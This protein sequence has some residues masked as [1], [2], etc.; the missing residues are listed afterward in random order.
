VG[1]PGQ[2]GSIQAGGWLAAITRCSSD[3][4][5]RQAIRQ[6]NPAERRA[7]ETLRS[8][9]PDSYLAHKREAITVHDREAGALADAIKQWAAARDQYEAPG[10]VMI[11]RDNYTRELANRAARAQ[12]RQAGLLPTTDIVI[13]GRAYAPGDRVIGRRN[14]RGH[15]IDNGTLGTVIEFD[16]SSGAMVIQTDT[17]APISLDRDYVADHLQHAYALTAHGAQGGTFEWVA[18]IGRPEEFTQE[19]AY[20]ALSRARQHTAIHIV[21]EAPE[22]ERQREE[23]APAAPERGADGA[24]DELSQAMRRRE[25]EPLAITQ[26]AQRLTTQAPAATL[27]PPPPSQGRLSGA[28][29][30][31]RRNDQGLRS[32]SLRT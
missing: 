32:P 24:W 18:V 22:R 28:E 26:A 4:D 14:H 12:L 25:F 10:A 21:A 9:D 31:R 15:D 3:P 23:Y 6:E 13:G 19:W 5:L 20:T 1:D 17:G 11:A 16:P 29:R 2:L 8:G 7:L 30:L 27:R